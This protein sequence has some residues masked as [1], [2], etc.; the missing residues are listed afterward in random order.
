MKTTAIFIKMAT[1]DRT[2]ERKGVFGNIACCRKA[3]RYTSALYYVKRQNR[4]R[5]RAQL[6][7]IPDGD[8]ATA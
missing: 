6:E 2:N 1:G 3:E 8:V 4:E 7:D 5:C